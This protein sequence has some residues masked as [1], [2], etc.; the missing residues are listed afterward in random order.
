MSADQIEVFYHKS[1]FF[2]V[3]H[4]DG[5]VG[6]INPRGMINCGFYSERSAIPLRTSF[7]IIN[8]KPSQEAIIESKP[9][10]VRELEVDVTMDI[11]AAAS[12][13]KWLGLQLEQLRVKLNISDEQWNTLVGG[14]K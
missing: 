10:L 7:S 11:N 14:V 5:C 13:H 8:G 4:A 1:N 9:G 6:G 3:V 12:F 2:R